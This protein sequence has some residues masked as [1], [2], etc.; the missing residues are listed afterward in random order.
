MIKIETQ[1]MELAVTKFIKLAKGRTAA[2]SATFI[3]DLN[4]VIVNGTPVKTGFLRASWYA[5]LNTP[6]SLQSTHDGDKAG[7]IT[8]ARCNLL[9]ATMKIG[10]TFYMVNGA[11]YAAHVEYG[12]KKMRPRRMVGSAL[13]QINKIAKAAAIKVRDLG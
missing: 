6:P 4:Y 12:T 7:S 9:A 1:K 11:N 8:V 5:S 13:S 3:Q 10:E 2:W